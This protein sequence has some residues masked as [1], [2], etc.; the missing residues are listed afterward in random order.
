VCSVFPTHMHGCDRCISL[1]ACLATRF[2]RPH[3]SR[4]SPAL[5]A[6]HCIVSRKRGA[7]VAGGWSR[8]AIA[9]LW[10]ASRGRQ[11]CVSGWLTGGERE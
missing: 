2:A 8:E 3:A 9:V 6:F 7:V 11:H 4:G 1:L 5:S 10:V